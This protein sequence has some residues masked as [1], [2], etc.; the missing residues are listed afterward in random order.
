ML[1][2]LESAITM[3]S[4]NLGRTRPFESDGHCKGAGDGRHAGKLGA[5]EEGANIGR[6]QHILHA[7]GEK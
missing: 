4:N 2:T 5:E 3:E 7:A 1:A 6:L